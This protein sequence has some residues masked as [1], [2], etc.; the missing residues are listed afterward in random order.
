M[1][2]AFSLR[3]ARGIKRG[4]A[5]LTWR[6]FYQALP[7]E[8]SWIWWG[9]RQVEIEL[10]RSG[11]RL[12][13]PL[14]GFDDAGAER[15][16]VLVAVGQNAPAGAGD[17]TLTAAKRYFSTQ[18]RNPHSGDLAAKIFVFFLLFLKCFSDKFAFSS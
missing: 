14:A 1:H 9:R 7:F 18:R 15:P 6:L 3:E 2:G 4:V 10:R 16:A 12:A 5:Q 8:L 11:Q 17:G 13:Q